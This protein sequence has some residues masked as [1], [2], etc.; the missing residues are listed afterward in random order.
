MHYAQ[1]TPARIAFAVTKSSGVID[2]P[3]MIPLAAYDE[4]VIGK[5]HNA[6]TGEWESLPPAPDTRPRH[7]TEGAWKDRLGFALVA[8]IA[9][10]THPICIGMKEMLNNRA[11]VNL[12]RPDLPVLL[13]MMVEQSLPEPIPGLPGSGPITADKVAEVL[14]GQVLEEERP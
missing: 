3:D 9:A 5:R 13:G 6:E 12:D 10:S 2:A 7:I 14:G 11:H 1:I 8:G 4:T